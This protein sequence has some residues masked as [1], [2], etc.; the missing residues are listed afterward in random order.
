MARTK[1][2]IRNAVAEELA[3]KIVGQSIQNKHVV[4]IEAKYDEVYEQLKVRGL[5]TWTST[6]SVPNDVAPY[7]EKL[8]ALLC[9]NVYGI[10]IERYQRIVA[11]T[12]I[13]GELAY[14]KIKEL[15]SPYYES[16]E[17]AVDY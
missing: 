6:G 7:I 5:A 13:D 17:S 10:P 12:G 9:A 4:K 14:S 16:Q 1:T 3:I 2:D 15:V 8:V 11:I